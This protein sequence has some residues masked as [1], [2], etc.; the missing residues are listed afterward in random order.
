M[1]VEQEEKNLRKVE[2]LPSLV[3]LGMF[4]DSKLCGGNQAHAMGLSV[5]E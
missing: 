1:S 5:Y 3:M 4:F 2:V